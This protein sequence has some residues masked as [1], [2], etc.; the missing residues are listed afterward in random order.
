MARYNYTGCFQ[1]EEQIARA[2]A[3][4]AS[5]TFYANPP[6]PSSNN[7]ASPASSASQRSRSPLRARSRSPLVDSLCP[8]P[9]SDSLYNL[10]RAL[11]P[12]PPE[13]SQTPD[14]S[15]PPSPDY[16]LSPRNRS[17]TPRPT[18]PRSRL[19]TPE[20]IRTLPGVSTRETAP[21]A[22]ERR[23]PA[24][25]RRDRRKRLREARASG[26]RPSPPPPEVVPQVMNDMGIISVRRKDFEPLTQAEVTF[27]IESIAEHG[28]NMNLRKF[29]SLYK[30][31]LRIFCDS[32][33]KLQNIWASRLS[34]RPLES[35][36]GFTFALPGVKF[37]EYK[38]LEC[39]LPA[40]YYSEERSAPGKLVKRFLIGCPGFDENHAKFARM[41]KLKP[42]ADFQSSHF[43]EEKSTVFQM[44]VSQSLFDFIKSKSFMTRLAGKWRVRWS[45]C[46]REQFKNKQYK[47]LEN[48]ASYWERKRYV[49]FMGS[50]NV[51]N[52]CFDFRSEIC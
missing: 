14:I 23:T 5:T 30:N 20:L 10:A 22:G 46:K 49:S 29:T 15:L 40:R 47:N 42:N 6:S 9:P 12:E 34:L 38:K 21:S 18:D 1:I 32:K 33:T 39:R 2:E 4:I 8:S 51:I 35:H 7:T 50:R 41:I 45:V 44:D 19:S 27:I 36:P 17:P 3:R 26:D 24:Q 28:T 16:N 25:K 43:K 52:S 48:V 37:S 11:T 13:P 31:T